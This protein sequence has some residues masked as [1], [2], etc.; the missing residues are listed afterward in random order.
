M[1][2]KGQCEPPAANST[3]SGPGASPLEDFQNRVRVGNG[4]HV[5]AP[6]QTVK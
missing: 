4:E 6:R 2:D 5:L 3:V 1:I